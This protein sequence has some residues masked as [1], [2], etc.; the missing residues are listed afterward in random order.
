[1][2]KPNDATPISYGFNSKLVKKDGRIYEDVYKADG[3]YG[4]AIQAIIG[5]LQK[6]NEVAENDIQ[7]DYTQKLIDYYTTGDLKTWDEYNVAWG[8]DAGRPPC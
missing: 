6:A 7:R 5:W 4:E 3:L 8:P 2:R 1:M